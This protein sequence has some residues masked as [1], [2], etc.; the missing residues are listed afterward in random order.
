[1]T[2][3]IPNRDSLPARRAAAGLA[4]IG[5]GIGLTGC[6]QP[7]AYQTTL[8]FAAICPSESPA[9]DASLLLQNHLFNTAARLNLTCV[10]SGG[11]VEPLTV[12]KISAYNIRSSTSHIISLTVSAPENPTIH[13]SVKPHAFNIA[14]TPPQFG[15]KFTVEHSTLNGAPIG[16]VYNPGTIGNQP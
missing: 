10:G 4:A 13:T 14:I 1:M 8:N 11:S 7:Q 15:T 3:R 6:E 9:I 5:L 2:E 12:N 16:Q